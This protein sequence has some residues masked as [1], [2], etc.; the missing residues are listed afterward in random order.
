MA[1]SLSARTAL[2]GVQ[3]QQKA[4]AGHAR[5]NTQIVAAVKKVNSYDDNWSKGIGSVG[6]FLEDREKP[7]VNIFKQVEKKRLLST[8]EKAGLLSAAEK[9]GLSLSKIEKL[10]LLSTAERLGLLTLAEDLLTTEPGK[11]SSASLPFFVAAVGSLVLIPQD[12]VA[13]VIIAY[14]LALSAGAVATALFV[15]GFVVKSLQED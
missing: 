14:T 13:E 15:G 6:I 2:G 5:L 8:V 4:R 10:G 7:S 3:L 1:A 12:N 9:A 11:I